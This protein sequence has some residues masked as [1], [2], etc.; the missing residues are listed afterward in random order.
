MRLIFG[1]SIP[2][3]WMWNMVLTLNYY[4]EKNLLTA[5]RFAVIVSLDLS[6]AA[7]FLFFFSAFEENAMP[8]GWTLL[9]LG[10][11]L[12]HFILSYPIAW[13]FYKFFVESR[14]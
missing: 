2:L 13:Y 11:T 14:K 7:F 4:H 10:I 3:L 9:G 1:F 6:M 12:L 8:I 5:R